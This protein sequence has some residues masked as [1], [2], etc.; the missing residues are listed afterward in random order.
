MGITFSSV[1]SPLTA[2]PKPAPSTDISFEDYLGLLSAAYEWADSYDS[3]DWD[4]LRRCI[5]PTLRIDYRSFLN[6]LWEAMPAEEFIAMISDPNVLGNPLLRTQHFFG[7]S[8]WERVS[9]TEVIGYHQ[10]RVPHQVYTD[11]SLATVAVKGHAHSANTH[12]YRKVD[13]VWKFAGLDPQ[14][15]WFEYDFDKVFATG[16][17]QF[18]AEEATAADEKPTVAATASASKSANSVPKTP[19]AA[20]RGISVGA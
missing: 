2:A 20:Q 16:R 3:K 1:T 10:L 18:G 5:A 14:I 11:A 13:G 12:W 15:R 4:R 9:D 7:A 8:R 17:D 6:K 19:L